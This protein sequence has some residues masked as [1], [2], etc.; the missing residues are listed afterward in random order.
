M[1]TLEI[2]LVGT[3]VWTLGALAI[4]YIEEAKSWH[5][6]EKAALAAWPLWIPFALSV[7]T[8]LRWRWRCRD[9]GRRGESKKAYYRHREARSGC[10]GPSIPNP[11]QRPS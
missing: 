3:N 9:C 8:Y 5:S 7:R 11:H 2:V 4:V 6:D 10:P 1:S